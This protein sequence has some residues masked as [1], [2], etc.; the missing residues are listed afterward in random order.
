MRPIKNERPNPTRQP[1]SDRFDMAQYV[2][3][4]TGGNSG[5]GKATALEL[6]RTG[7]TVVITAR[8]ADRGARA[9][10]DLKAHAQSD[11]VHCINMDLASFASVQNG[12]YEFC[13]CFD[14]LDVLINNAGVLLSARNETNDGFET[15]FGV[16]HL[17]HFLLTVLLL[18]LMARSAPARIINV[19]STAHWLAVSGIDFDD[20]QSERRYDG[21]LAY[22]ASKLANIQFTRELARRLEGA[23]VTANSLCPGLIASDFATDGDTTGALRLVARVSRPFAMSPALAA[24]TPVYLASSP[25]LSRVSGRHFVM[26][27]PAPVSWHAHDAAACRKLWEVSESLIDSTGARGRDAAPDDGGA[28]RDA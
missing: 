6:A 8:N 25:S 5:L 16:N 7:A 15:T 14:R 10:A 22:A 4:I 11:R 21:M 3:L 26:R 18:D 13:R 28:S 24:Q 1:H 27:M 2:V 9:V 23:G 12:A 19:A 17:G 20:L